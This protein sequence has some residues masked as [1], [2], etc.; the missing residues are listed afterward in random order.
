MYFIRK[1]DKQRHTYNKPLIPECGAIIVPNSDIIEDYDL[2]IYPKDLPDN[3]PEHTYLNKLSQYVDPMIFPLLFPAGDLGWST[4]HPKHPKSKNGNLSIFQYYLYRLS[5]RPNSKNFSPLLYGGRLTQQFFIHAY[6]MMESNR[7]NFFRNNQKTLRI[8]CYQSLLDHVTNSAS[9]ISGNFENREQLGNLFI[10]LSTYIGGQRYMQQHY[11]DAMAIMRKFGK[12]DLLITITCN[13]KWK[14]LK[15]IL[16]DFPKNT[17]PND[18]PNIMVRL[19]H[20]KLH[21]ISND[22]LKEEVFGKVIS[23]IYKI[24]F[25][26]RGLPH[27][28]LLITLHFDNKI[29]TPDDVDRH[30]SAEI[31]LNNKQL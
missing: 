1:N 15:E 24:E 11:Q 31:P 8:E 6:I 9:N 3:V 22:I 27:A 29:I 21:L 13:Q 18:I 7:M 25:Q 28:H 17:I 12:P 14:E 5:Y 20:T 19:F 4:N 16:K 30:I 26:K 10:L 23:Y 2:C